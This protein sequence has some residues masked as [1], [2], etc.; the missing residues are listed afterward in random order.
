ML[1]ITLSCTS[2]IVLLVVSTSLSAELPRAL[3]VGVAG[4]AFDHFDGIN[5]QAH[6]DLMRRT[7]NGEDANQGTPDQ[8]IYGKVKDDPRL[9]RIGSWMRRYSVDE[10][11]QILNVLLGQMSIVGPRPPIP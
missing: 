8:P 4:H 10:L 3:R 6:R 2:T 1:K 5:D 9:T 7:I 11:P